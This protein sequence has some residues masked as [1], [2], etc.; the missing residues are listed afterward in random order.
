MTLP[1]VAIATGAL[2]RIKNR[3]RVPSRLQLLKYLGRA[4]LAKSQA[5]VVEQ[6]CRRDEVA[7][8]AQ[9]LDRRSAETEFL[10]DHLEAIH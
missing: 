1:S 7:I 6:L 2:V 3:G 9:C 4:A 10:V 8:S 5:R